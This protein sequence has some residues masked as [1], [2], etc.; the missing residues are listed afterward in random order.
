MIMEDFLDIDNGMVILFVCRYLCS[1]SLFCWCWCSCYGVAVASDAIPRN[2]RDQPLY[3][4]LSASLLLFYFF[5][6]LLFSWSTTVKNEAIPT[7]CLNTMEGLNALFLLSR[8]PHV[9]RQ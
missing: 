6:F 9:S 7:S 1:G 2:M 8:Q 4:S 3:P 5:G